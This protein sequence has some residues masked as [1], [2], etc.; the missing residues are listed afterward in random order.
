MS[1]RPKRWHVR[2]GDCLKL[3]PRLEPASVDA[4]VT[5]PPYGIDFNDQHWD[6]KAIA[7]AATH[8]T[9]R[10]PNN[11]AEAFQTWCGLWATELVRVL[12]PGAHL[13]CFGSP[14]MA[15]RLACALEAAGLELR[16]TLMWLYGTGLPKS[17]RLPGGQATHL[18][19][20]YEPILL[21]RKPPAGTVEHN[22]RVHRTGALNV[23]A[24]SPVD[25]LD[26]RTRW[27]ANVVIS[28]QPNC[29]D[30]TCE[31]DCPAAV[32]DHSAQGT[33]TRSGL[34]ARP[35]RLFYV[36]KASRAERNAG[37]ERL[38]RRRLD[39]FPNASDA[40]YT[41]PAA[42]NAHPT[43]KPI[44]VMRWLVRLITPPNGLV[45]DP[46][47]G[48]GTTGCAALIERRRFTGI[49]LDPQYVA[50]ARARIT[51]WARQPQPCTNHHPDCDAQHHR[52]HRR[53]FPQ[54]KA[55]PRR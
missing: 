48:S 27:P 46:F 51:H 42:A 5:D 3:L 12:R 37:C 49:E 18:K 26:H 30:A 25:P 44:A 52:R 2:N 43:V 13:A 6:G 35:S 55:S 47:C 7:A 33:R 4:V 15:H 40:A 38:P 23:D 34:V 16:D 31:I 41:P 9:G 19:P 29:T 11:P 14:R 39:L 10:S 53:P 1:R 24:C 32:I 22:R 21:A 36:A 8:A 20:A 28:H 17:R 45:L 50:I 54:P